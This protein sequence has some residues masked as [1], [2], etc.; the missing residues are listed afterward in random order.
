MLNFSC[1]AIK[2]S[3]ETSFTST[4]TELSQKGPDSCLSHIEHSGA[5]PVLPFLLHS[6]FLHPYLQ[7]PSH[8]FAIPAK[9]RSMTLQ[10]LHVCVSMLRVIVAQQPSFL[11]PIT[12]PCNYKKYRAVPCFIHLLIEVLVYFIFILSVKLHFCEI[13]LAPFP[14]SQFFAFLSH[15]N[16]WNSQTGYAGRPY[17]MLL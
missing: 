14:I 2:S 13:V 11:T 17:N 16:L 4:H 15:L 8:R 10:S 1:C 6:P 3:G 5:H 9:R 7:F 12:L